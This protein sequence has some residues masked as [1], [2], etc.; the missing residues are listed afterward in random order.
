M[1]HVID[2]LI[3]G[4]YLIG[5]VAI[6]L[7]Y[8][9]RQ[10]STDD[11]FTGGGRMNSPLQTVLVGLSIAATLFSGIS[12]LAYPS[13]VF[14]QG[15]AILFGMICFPLAWVLLRYWFLPRYLQHEADEPYQIMERRFGG[16]VRTLAATMF[17]LLRV[18]WMAAL[19]YAPTVVLMGAARLDA[20]WFWP[21][22]LTIGISSTI[23]TTLGGIRG[24]IITDAI[25]FLI[26]MGGIL[27]VLIYIVVELPVPISEAVREI[28]AS[29]R[30]NPVDLSLDPTRPFTL[31]AVL[32]GITVSNL[33][34]YAADQMS[35][36]R[37]LALGDARTAARSFGVN[38]IGA[39]LV[40]MLLGGV[41]LA[42]TVWYRVVPDSNLPQ[43]ADKVFP[44]FVASQLPAGIAGLLLAAILAA[45]MSSMTSGINALA[46]TI[47]LDFRGR[48][49]SALSPERQLRFAKVSSLIVGVVS[50]AM[51]G[52]VHHLGDIF[53]I[54]Q[55]LL[56]VFLGPLLACMI[57]ALSSWR[58]HRWSVSIGMI[59]GS[60]S[61]WAVTFSPA[62]SLWV[63]PAACAATLLLAMV[64]NFL[65][66]GAWRQSAVVARDMASVAPSLSRANES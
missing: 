39:L 32:I 19:I 29:G 6:G 47:T 4:V 26:I 54:A 63:A 17:L 44:Y 11:Y 18:G 37:Y 49:G 42:L 43:A 33:G 38:I 5:T 8:G 30:L 2:M 59:G 57:M 61:G 34:S 1:L 21:L 22:V 16:G 13:V 41:G 20:G 50:T 12:F 15:T 3:I 10:R 25:Q 53:D 52:L 66:P 24:V 35:L 51:A 55:T 60:L 7:I 28:Q 14:S 9:G 62:Q 56:G 45:T 27:F 36:Q 31:W 40:I 48:M 64:I 46:A 65:I 58:L 23:Y